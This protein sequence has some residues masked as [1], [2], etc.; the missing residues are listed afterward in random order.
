M[1]G[2]DAGVA[3]ARRRRARPEP[4]AGRL[5]RRAGRPVRSRRVRPRGG[6]PPR[7]RRDRRRPAGERSSARRAR[8]LA[9]RSRARAA[10]LRRLDR[11]PLALRHPRAHRRDR[12]DG[13]LGRRH[14]P[15]DGQLDRPRPLEPARAHRRRRSRVHRRDSRAWRLRG[16]ADD[17][18]VP[19][20]CDRA[21]SGARALGGR[22]FSRRDERRHRRR[23]TA[24]QRDGGLGDVFQRARR[25]AGD[26]AGLDREG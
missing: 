9:A 17:D 22:V 13:R 16:P 1:A 20:V 18:V 6:A 23:S 2:P 10:A 11:A 12:P 15:R 19:V 3:S 8:A 21:R 24:R 7:A 4:R 26:W 5:G 25:A 14:Q